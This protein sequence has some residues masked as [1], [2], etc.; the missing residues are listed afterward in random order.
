MN[1]VLIKSSSQYQRES[2]KEDIDVEDPESRL[3]KIEDEEELPKDEE[4]LTIGMFSGTCEFCK[5]PVKPFPTL[6]Q[7]LQLPPEE[8]YCCNDY[9]EFVEYVL[10]TTAEL[11]KEQKEK[12]KLISVK[13]HEHVGSK[14]ERNAAK[15]KAVQR[16]G[17]INTLK[18]W[19]T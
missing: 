18:T 1:I 6:D 19:D 16:Y 4:G 7:Q 13:V 3:P 9:R 17:A 8:L 15:E 5:K 10:N 2:Q 12:T 14:Q 11:E